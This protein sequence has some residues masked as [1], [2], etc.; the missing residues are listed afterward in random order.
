MAS[1]SA[2]KA[3]QDT[4]LLKLPAE[5]LNT[6]YELAIS[7][8]KP[9][10]IEDRDVAKTPALLHTCQQTRNDASPIYYGQNTFIG[11]IGREYHPYGRRRVNS[12]IFGWRGW[13]STIG[14]KSCHQIKTL[15]LGWTEDR[16][17]MPD[18]FVR[19][20]QATTLD[21]SPGAGR[22]S[23][24]EVPAMDAT[25]HIYDI[26]HRGVCLDAITC[27]EHSLSPP[28]EVPMPSCDPEWDWNAAQFR[29]Q[30]RQAMDAKIVS[31]QST[32]GC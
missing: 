30:W 9:I 25:M 21:L 2:S 22:V 12:W 23:P 3:Q 15:M 27:M 19:I 10:Y 24:W 13:L 26:R 7:N 17:A 8:E 1:S 11:T 32:A 28:G 20:A 29:L 6:I 5:L 18:F 4:P 16:R 14:T 31:L